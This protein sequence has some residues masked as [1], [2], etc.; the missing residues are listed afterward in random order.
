MRLRGSTVE[1]EDWN[2]SRWKR[3]LG[4]AGLGQNRRGVAGF[5]EDVFGWR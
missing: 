4:G 1:I 3:R 2:W 5:E